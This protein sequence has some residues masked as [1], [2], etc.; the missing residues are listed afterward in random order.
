MSG[1]D[2][3]KVL[4]GFGESLEAIR[5]NLK[6]DGNTLTSVVNG[7]TY[8]VGSFETPSLKELRELGA[9]LRQQFPG[10]LKVINRC[11][12]I[13]SIHAERANRYSV[14][15]AASQFNCLEFVGPNIKP[16]DGVTGYVFDKT[17]GPACS[18]ACGPATV[19]RN[20][21]VPI[22]KA[23]GSVQVG[24]TTRLQIECLRDV[25]TV[26]G[27]K[28]EGRYFKVQGGY[29]LATDEGLH[30]LNDALKNIE[31][32]DVRQ[33]LRIGVHS[34]VQ[35]TSTSWLVVLET[36]LCYVFGI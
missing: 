1:K 11:G 20:Y 16:E 19:V 9:S 14:F 34:D 26:V 17:Q 32:D 31:R 21:F 12:E 18:I 30:K 24:Q 23:D 10:K 28:P 15:Q 8:T 29:T 5:T 6:F 7:A 4:F 35:V 22:S 33:S 3:F 2:W 13:S 36:S 25:S 27:N